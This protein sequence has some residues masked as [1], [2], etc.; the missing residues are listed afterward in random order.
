MIMEKK[1]SLR[2]NLALILV[3]MLA[4]GLRWFGLGTEN[5]WIDEIGHTQVAVSED[6]NAVFEGVKEHAAA[7]PLDYVILHFY[8]K[9]TGFQD[10]FQ[11]RLPY[12]FYGVLSVFMLYKLGA[13]VYDHRVGIAS[14]FVLSVSPYHI[15]YSQEVRFYS[16][17]VLLSLISTWLFL[18]TVAHRTWRYWGLWGMVGL[19]GLYNHYF[20]GLVLVIQ[21]G[22]ILGLVVWEKA[23]NATPWV[24]SARNLLGPFGLIS[25]LVI[26]GFLPWVLW[27]KPVDIGQERLLYV[28]FL[29]A[30]W[31]FVASLGRFNWSLGLAVLGLVGLF[32]KAEN[33]LFAGLTILPIIGVIAIDNWGGYFFNPRQ[34]IFSHPFY[35]LTFI[36][37]AAYYGSTVA[38]SVQRMRGVQ[39]TKKQT[40]KF[41]LVSLVMVASIYLAANLP[42]LASYYGEKQKTDW[43]GVVEFIQSRNE[44]Q[45]TPAVLTSLDWKELTFYFNKLDFS[46]ADSPVVQVNGVDELKALLGAEESIW[47]IWNASSL[48]GLGATNIPPEMEK[49]LIDQADARYD[50]DDEIRLFYIHREE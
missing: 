22:Y 11:L 2:P 7:T 15:A 1:I 34:V 48:E 17:T 29:D 14:A 36:T 45:F 43:S 41:V 50:Y 32:W 19:A 27:A 40:G 4:A 25:I 46:A 13:E 35:F 9:I 37:G 5:F 39:F 42:G 38:G 26:L 49:L 8:Q 47:V 6:L 20:F 12:F 21:G 18:R 31:V 16:L 3:L 33:F 30:L 23:R 28:P 24:E 10:E 44:G